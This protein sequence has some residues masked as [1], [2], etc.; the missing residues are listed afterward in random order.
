MTIQYLMSSQ[1]VLTVGL[2]NLLAGYVGAEVAPDTLIER[3]LWPQRANTGFGTSSVLKN[4][5]LLSAGGPL[6]RAAIKALDKLSEHSLYKG[7]GR[8]HMLGTAFFPD[9]GLA[10]KL[11]LENGQRVENEWIRNGLLVRILNC[12]PY[13]QPTPTGTEAAERRMRQSITVNHLE[14]FDVEHGSAPGS[15]PLDDG[16][17]T[18]K[19]LLAIILSES[20]TILF[21]TMVALQSSQ[22]TA[23]IYLA[24]LAL[25]VFAALTTLEREDLTLTHRGKSDDLG[26][27]NT[28]P[29]FEIH[30][31]GEGFHVISG[32]SELVLPFFRHYGH[33]IRCRWREVLQMFVVAGLGAC[34]PLTFVATF[35]LPCEIQA[36]WTVLQ[37]YLTCAMLIARFA[38]GDVWGT[39]EERVGKALVAHENRG[40]DKSVVLES[41][42]GCLIGARLTR[43]VHG[44][45]TDGK[46]EVM[47]IVALSRFR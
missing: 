29:K 5:L 14:L 11:H 37:V 23:L 31:P 16:R 13:L 6:H 32:P 7:A 45:Y 4:S 12:I 44:S 35:L 1:A 19:H 22:T 39:T 28:K 40:G 25:K 27:P 30:V 8:G 3:T 43:S 15:I 34:Y 24:P 46:A 17:L 41:Q 2:L 36:W 9:T 18:A 10:Y 20:P 47:R 26:P 21:A 42:T 38:G 33:P